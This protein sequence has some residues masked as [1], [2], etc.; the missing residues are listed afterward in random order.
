[1]WQTA[2]IRIARI[3]QISIEVHLSFTLVIAWGGWQG[4]LQYGD[5]QGL[6]YGMVVVVLLFACVLLHELGHGLQARM[7]GL[8]V[9]RITLL[10]I[11]GLAQLDTP[12][13]YA[14]HEL[15]IALA[16]PAVNLIM[17]IIIGVIL[18]AINP[19]AFSAPSIQD[20]VYQLAL[21]PF[22]SPSLS[23]IMLYLFGTN[24]MLF[25]FNMLPAFPMDGGRILRSGLALFLDYQLAT[26]IAAWLGRI[27]AIGMGFFGIIGWPRGGIPP[28]PILFIV[29]LVV[30][31]GA[32]H[33]EIYVRRRRALVQLEVGDIV[34]RST[35]VISP[36]DAITPG[37]I[38][39]LHRNDRT[40]PALID[41]RLVGL[42]SYN[43]IRRSVH[44]EEAATV[45]HV[46]RTDFPSMRKTDTLWVAL[47]EMNKHYLAALPVIQDGQFFGMIGL[48]DIQQAWRYASHRFRHSNSRLAPGDSIHK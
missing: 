11:G 28:N 39:R 17:A 10:P 44:P 18:V 23:G 2:G 42:L 31:Y 33:E 26:Q 19:F 3:G 34:Q 38:R 24:L 45:A 4:W 32:R 15:V 12:P 9:R 30:Y 7:F 14:W 6:I 5:V 35:E 46:M 13:S 29:A 16:G 1:M 8:S 37:L 36:W 43:D 22:L 20:W 25:L 41:G 27:M 21:M 48:D 47:Q 40:L